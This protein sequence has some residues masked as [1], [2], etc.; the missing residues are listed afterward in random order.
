MYKIFESPSVELEK[1]EGIWLQ[2]SNSVCN[3]K[4]KH[5]FLSVKQEIK[6][7][8]FLDVKEIN[9]VL[10][11]I[12]KSNL[13]TIYLTGGEPFL[14]PKFNDILR[15]SLKYANVI[16]YT[17]GTF[18]NEKR[19]KNIEKIVSETEH[20]V[21]FF[22]SLDNFMQGRHDEYRGANIFK[23]VLN[24]LSYL[25][26]YNFNIRIM[27]TNIKNE[28]EEYLKNG[29]DELFKQKGLK[30]NKEDVTII[31]LLKIGEYAKHYD[32]EAKE[33]C[34]DINK[35]KNFDENILDCKNSR[36]ISQDGIFSCPAL[37]SDSRG[38]LG[39]DTDNIPK[40]VYLETETC[41]TCLNCSHKLFGI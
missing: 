3:L 7:K 28:D 20:T 39:E 32:F 37:I 27:C 31:P 25:E 16:I 18:F 10:K 23:K 24:G 26:K 6:K 4:C 22:V 11:K 40:K 1:L 30:L 17:N 15:D 41:F 9:E 14:H 5:C 38:K 35:I 19:I 36:V 2:L 33:V 21:S 8:N 34:I 29:F 12:D 13:K